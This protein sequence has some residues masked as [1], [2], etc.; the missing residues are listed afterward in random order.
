M[1]PVEPMKT[2]MLLIL[3]AA[4][5]VCGAEPLPANAEALKARRDA[6]IA[7]VNRVYAAELEKFKKQAMADG[8]LSAAT[9]I[10][11]EI[12]AVS[13]NPF[14]EEDL[15]G[16]WTA[17]F[18]GEKSV[19]RVITKSHVVDEIGGK[20][21]FSIKGDTIFVE[22]GGTLWERLKIDPKNPD[23][24]IGTNSGGSRLVYQR[25]GKAN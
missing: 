19:K 14:R 10:Q 4:A 5:A 7:E 13:P 25:S 11:K 24:L 2:M 17:T 22:W 3:A 12:E 21:P 20:H 6:K 1:L 16:V 8:N 15:D 18:S 9:V 23:T